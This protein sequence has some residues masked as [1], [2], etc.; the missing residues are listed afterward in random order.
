[1]VS[2][3]FLASRV[4][5]GFRM[6]SLSPLTPVIGFATGRRPGDAYAAMIA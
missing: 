3:P 1:M 2:S 4:L 6:E 5:F